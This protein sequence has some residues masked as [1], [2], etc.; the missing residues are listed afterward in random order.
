MISLMFALLVAAAGW[1]VVRG[2]H[3]ERTALILFFVS[4]PAAYFLQ[5]AR[6][7]PPVRDRPIRAV[8]DGYV[9]SGTCRS[10]HPGNHASWHA[11]Y[12]RTMTQVP[13]PDA[14][15][16]FVPKA[17]VIVG[18]A[19]PPSAETASSIF[20]H[21]RERVSGYKRVRRLEFSDLPK[22]ISGKIR[23]V[24]LREQEALRPSTGTRNG[25][26]F[27][28]ADLRDEAVSGSP[29][30]PN[31]TSSAVCDVRRPALP[32]NR[33]SIESSCLS[34]RKDQGVP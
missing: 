19:H 17:Y 34:G 1:L 10:C 8:A 24:E 23:R 32:E 29:A 12:H 30:E 6:A 14:M 11:S 4:W 20:A 9:G 31:V 7:G 25:R 16:G 5:L 18:P 33:A 3:R 13:S 27:L 28:E 22:T 26:E 15:R 2:N 21:M